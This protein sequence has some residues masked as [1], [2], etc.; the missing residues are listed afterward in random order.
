MDKW[1][2]SHASVGYTQGTAQVLYA[3]LGPDLS[4]EFAELV[5]RSDKTS[6]DLRSLANSLEERV[7]RPPEQL[8]Y[9]AIAIGRLR[10]W[11][12]A[13]HGSAPTDDQYEEVLRRVGWDAFKMF[14]SAFMD[15]Y[16]RFGFDEQTLT[17]Y[18]R[19]CVDQGM[20]FTWPPP[21]VAYERADLGPS[22]A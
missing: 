11:L 2:P 22:D 14:G 21:A 5:R 17:L 12:E 6:D 15:M 4:R 16:R 7:G 8:F 9:M 1:I 3:V 20:Q 13:Q 18:M 19:T 10:H